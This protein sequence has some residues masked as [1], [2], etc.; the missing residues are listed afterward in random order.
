MDQLQKEGIYVLVGLNNVNHNILATQAWDRDLQ[1]RFISIIDGFCGYK[2]VLGFY[3][4]GSPITVPYIRAA[5]RD[6]KSY[7]KSKGRQVPIGYFGSFRGR[8]FSD[9]VNCGEGESA[10]DFM[11]FDDG[12]VC[13]N[14]EKAYR[15]MDILTADHSTFSIPT[16]LY[17]PWCDPQ[18]PA[19]TSDFGLLFQPNAIGTLSGSVAFSYFK[20]YQVYEHS[21]KC[22]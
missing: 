1:K 13:D 12:A 10:V 9:S 17:N 16:F 6:L 3:L 19:N 4:T 21:G 18:T 15:A 8:G 7:V 2:N 22:S 20:P 11:A 5:A 14:A